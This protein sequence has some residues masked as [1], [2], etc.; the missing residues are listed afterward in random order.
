M[1]G[2]RQHLLVE[3]E[4]VGHEHTPLSRSDRFGAME[5]E[6]AK[7]AHAPG[8]F[9][10]IHRPN[11]SVGI[12]NHRD[13]MALADR[14]QGIHVAKVAVE[15]H[16]HDRLGLGRDR[17]LHLFWV[18]TP[19]VREDVHKHRYGAQV[20]DRCGRCD[21][22]GVG[23]DHLISWPDPQGMH[24]HVQ[25]TGAAAGGDGV[26]HAQM[27]LERLLEANDVVVTVLAPAI[28]RSGGGVSHLQFGDGGLGVGNLADFAG[29]HLNALLSNAEVLGSPSPAPSPA[30]AAAAPRSGSRAAPAAHRRPQRPDAQG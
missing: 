17:G 16:R 11:G 7:A 30:T 20:H 8:P 13:A 18:Q 15:M 26:V 28:G 29:H 2:Q 22:I 21:P 25:R 19:A 24:A 23:H 27:G 14:Q 3:I 6:G 10:V 9:V 1:V 12:I 5:G 4:V